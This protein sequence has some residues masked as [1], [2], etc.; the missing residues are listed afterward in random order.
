MNIDEVKRSFITLKQMLEDRKMDISNLS[1]I[2]D[3]ELLAMIKANQI[4]TL[5]V[6][7][8]FHIV[9]YI[10][11]KFKISDMKRYIPDDSHIILIFKEKINTQNIKNIKELT[12]NTIEI[13]MLSELMYNITHHYLVP[14]HD[15]CSSDEI[16]EIMTIYKIKQKTQ[17][18]CILKT[19]PM[20]RYLG[21][22]QGNIVKITRP[23]PSAGE[24]IVYRYCV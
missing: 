14:K 9:Y 4:F 16:N 6:N 12:T 24:T 11:S 8:N 22:K 15:I 1:C 5:K 3:Q 19:D 21:L 2:S 23:S 7:D 20:A 10:H 13:F 17:F 18:P